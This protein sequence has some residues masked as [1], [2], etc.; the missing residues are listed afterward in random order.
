LSALLKGE[1]TVFDRMLLVWNLHTW[2][3]IKAVVSELI[4]LL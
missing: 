3:A 1:P 2:Q 4:R